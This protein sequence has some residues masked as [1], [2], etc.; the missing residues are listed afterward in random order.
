MTPVFM[1]QE[2]TPREFTPREFMPQKLQKIRKVGLICVTVLLYVYL[3][4]S[5]MLY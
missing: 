4:I 1:S 2:F 5:N 3:Y